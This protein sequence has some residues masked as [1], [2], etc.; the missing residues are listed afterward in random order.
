MCFELRGR[1]GCAILQTS[2]CLLSVLLQVS[3]VSSAEA[4]TQGLITF[5]HVL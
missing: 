1:L 4:D 2:L 3:E 5:T